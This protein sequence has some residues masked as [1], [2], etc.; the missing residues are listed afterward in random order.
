MNKEIEGKSDLMKTKKDYQM[1]GGTPP[2]RPEVG[3]DVPYGETLDDDQ[4]H[5]YYQ[6]LVKALGEFSTDLNPKQQRIIRPV[7]LRSEEDLQYLAQRGIDVTRGQEL[8]GRVRE[9]I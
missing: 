3:D 9:T 4:L 7:V 2:H 5:E 1:A 6:G 8:F